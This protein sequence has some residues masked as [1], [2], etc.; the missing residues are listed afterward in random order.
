MGKTEI[1]FGRQQI[2]IRQGKGGKD[3][4]VPIDETT[5]AANRSKNLAEK[6]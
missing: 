5:N 2:F 1:N 6:R 3:R 4:D